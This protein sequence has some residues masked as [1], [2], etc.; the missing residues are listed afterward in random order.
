MAR[1]HGGAV[2]NIHHLELFY[3]VARAGGISRAVKRIP[4]GIQQPAV[5]GQIAALERELGVRLFERSP[6]RLT[7]AGAE[8][9]AFVEPFFGGLASIEAKLSEQ[10][11]PVLRIGAAELVLR[12]HLPPVIERLRRSEPRLRLSLRSGFQGELET[13]LLERSIDL[14]VTPL[15]RK[16]PRRLRVAPLLRVPLVLLVPK[17]A[18]LKSAA[19][20]WRDGRP[21][22]SL[23]ALPES[24]SVV[25]RFREGLR[26]RGVRWPT[27]IEASSLEAI[28]A[29]VASGAG[30]GLNVGLPEVV[31]HPKVRLLPLEGFASLE[32]VA[33]WSGEATPVMTEFLE[34]AQAYVRQAWPQWQ[35]VA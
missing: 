29:Y 13:A 2:L 14:A 32:I 16:P 12:H 34:N 22:E 5:S 17:A 33:L 21:Q 25:R 9:F 10:A 26:R 18:A 24:E 20:L 23:I 6:F 3:H 30:V 27:A 35:C 15:D 19:D 8:L 1:R 31:R 11:A 7:P 4:Y 28:T